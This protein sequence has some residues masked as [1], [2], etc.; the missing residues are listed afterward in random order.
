MM[1]VDGGLVT[2]RMAEKLGRDS[3][4][5]SSTA[6]TRV[7]NIMRLA[8]KA[9]VMDVIDGPRVISDG[10]D[11]KDGRLMTNLTGGNAQHALQKLVGRVHEHWVGGEEVDQQGNLK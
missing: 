5:K 8:L 3:A 9:A 11:Y 4:R 7:R 1:L 2:C 6:V 10:S